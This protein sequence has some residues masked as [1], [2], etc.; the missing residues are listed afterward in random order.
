MPEAFKWPRPTPK[1]EAVELSDEDIISIENPKENIFETLRGKPENTNE[2]IPVAFE[3]EKEPGKFQ[4]ANVHEAFSILGFEK[5]GLEVSATIEKKPDRLKDKSRNEDNIIADSETGLIGVLDGLGGMGHGDLASKMAE[6]TIPEAYKETLAANKGKGQAELIKNL[7]ESQLNRVSISSPEAAVQKRKDM[8]EKIEGIAGV[9][10][11]MARKAL[12]LVEAFTKVSADIKGTKGMTTACTGFVHT[13]PDGKRWAVVANTGDSG[14]F[15][16]RANGSAEKLTQEDSMSSLLLESG[17]TDQATLDQ[18]KKEPDKFFEIPLT[19][20]IVKAGGGTKADY[21]KFK[22]RNQILPITYKKLKKMMPAAL[23][24]AIPEPSLEYVEL[25]PGDE[26]ILGTDGLLDMFENPDTDDLDTKELGA[27]ADGG[28][29]NQQL[30]KLRSEAKKRETNYKTDDD[31][32][33]L[34]VKIK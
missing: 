21:E 27:A 26:L 6:E 11:E 10:T 24:G 33:I 19:Y 12:S 28:S 34:G 17:A 2:E 9:D 31:I 15:I 13:G 22:A 23:G 16:K 3:E 1:P 30:D 5:R 14:A 25:K 20:E 7:V 29:F 4:E 18:M 8:T 32:A